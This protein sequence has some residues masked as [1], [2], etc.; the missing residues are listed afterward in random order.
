MVKNLVH[1]FYKKC[2][3]QKYFYF[4]FGV[5]KKLICIMLKNLFFLSSSCDPYAFSD[6]LFYFLF[7]Q[8]PSWD[9]FLFMCKISFCIHQNHFFFCVSSTWHVLMSVYEYNYKLVVGKKGLKT[10]GEEDIKKGWAEE[11]NCLA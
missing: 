3:S 10:R 9:V 5:V 11:D 2:G 4:Y 6:F 7:W 8:M 1:A